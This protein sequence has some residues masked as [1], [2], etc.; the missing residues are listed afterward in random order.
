VQLNTLATLKIPAMT[1]GSSD[2]A[3]PLADPANF[4]NRLTLLAMSASVY[5]AL[6]ENRTAVGG[7][8]NLT[9]TLDLT[10]TSVCY[11]V[12]NISAGISPPTTAHIH[13]GGPSLAGLDWVMLFSGGF[14]SADCTIYAETRRL[15]LDIVWVPGSYYFD[16]H[17]AAYP[18][19]VVRW[20][21]GFQGCGFRV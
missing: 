14:K 13:S 6:I 20:V 11:T 1:H 17:N 12:T 10:A 15:L 21:L 18:D 7:T 19:G 4:T 16:A 9:V 5:P 3:G 2:S 8:G